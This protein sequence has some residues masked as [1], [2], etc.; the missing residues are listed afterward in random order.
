MVSKWSEPGKLLEGASFVG[1]CG[2]ALGQVPTKWVSS[3]VYSQALPVRSALFLRIA[4]R[5]KK[6]DSAP[7]DSLFLQDEVF[8]AE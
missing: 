6:S 3:K 8:P 1:G 2:Q 7:T 5:G 4:S